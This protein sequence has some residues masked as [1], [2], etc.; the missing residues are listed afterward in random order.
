MK[1]VIML[2][3]L[4]M[5]Q[6]CHKTQSQNALVKKDTATKKDTLREE[7]IPD[8]L[9]WKRKESSIPMLYSNYKYYDI[10]GD[11]V[12]DSLILL[13]GTGNGGFSSLSVM[14][15]SGKN[16]QSLVFEKL[17]S[18]AYI[19]NL[20]EFPIEYTHKENLAFFQALKEACFS[21]GKKAD[22]PS[23]WIIDATVSNRLWTSHPYFEQV[24]RFKP[25][26]HTGEFQFPYGCTMEV[27]NDSL[28]KV[29][30]SIVLADTFEKRILNRKE[31]VYYVSFGGWILWGLNEEIKYKG[32]RVQEDYKVL[33]EVAKSDSYTLYTLPHALVVKRGEAYAWIFVSDYE[34][35]KGPEKMRWNSVKGARLKGK[36]AFI[37][38]ELGPIAFNYKQT[39]IVNIESGLCVKLKENADIPD[40]KLFEEMEKL[41]Q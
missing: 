29:A 14:V 24:F 20:Y 37:F 7:I 8:S 25:R 30:Q 21:E 13:R 36:Y 26:F 27:N 5:Y 41:E 31:K 34:L 4:L 17:F 35:T 16:Q 9:Q 10:N 39:F 11:G 28:E 33:K 32:G 23:Q 12:R 19:K 22:P 2:S 3:F 40:E 38:H 15:K 6:A 1:Y 18:P